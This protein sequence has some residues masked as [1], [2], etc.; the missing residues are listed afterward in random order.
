MWKWQCLGRHKGAKRPCYPSS[1]TNTTRR[2]EV[3]L[4]EWQCLLVNQRDYKPHWPVMTLGYHLKETNT[5]QQALCRAHKST[6]G[7]GCSVTLWGLFAHKEC[8]DFICSFIH[9]RWEMQTLLLCSRWVVEQHKTVVN[10]NCIFCL[11]LWSSRMELP[12]PS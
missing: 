2:L 8:P 12:W 9:P 5:Q 7:H 1:E 4:K 3:R 11:F 6:W 10:R